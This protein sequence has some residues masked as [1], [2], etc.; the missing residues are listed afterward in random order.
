[1]LPTSHT[2][3]AAIPVLPEKLTW[4]NFV[5]FQCSLMD[6][7]SRY[8]A[9]RTSLVGGFDFDPFDELPPYATA[10]E[11]KA[12]LRADKTYN[13]YRDHRISICATLYQSLS[14]VYKIESTKMH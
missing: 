3:K 6:T 13:Q 1:M 9:V 5:T 2:N 14:V 11:I 10:A 12:F 8:T 4:T 7:A